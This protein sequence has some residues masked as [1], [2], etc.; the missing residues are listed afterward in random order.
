MAPGL[1]FL[2]VGASGVGKGTLMQGALVRPGPTGR[3]ISVRRAVTRPPGPGEEHEPI[4]DEEF[5]SRA[6]AGGF[7]VTWAAHGLRYGLPGTIRDQFASGRHVIADGS[8]ASVPR[9]AEILS[10]LVVMRSQRRKPCWVIASPTAAA[11]TKSRPS[12][13]SRAGCPRWTVRSRWSGLSTTPQ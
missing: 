8:R 12:H 3:Y 6:A 7:L 10:S 9:L 2:I 1:L 4:T 11:R 13:A 5:D